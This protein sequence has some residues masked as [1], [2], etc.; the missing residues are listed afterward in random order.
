MA[1][2]EQH[3]TAA[4]RP[5]RPSPNRDRRVRV[6]ASSRPPHRIVR[7]SVRSANTDRRLSIIGFH[8]RTKP[9]IDFTPAWAT[10]SRTAR[11]SSMIHAIG[12]STRTW[13][14]VGTASIV[15][16]AWTW[17]GPLRLTISTRSYQARP[18]MRCGF[19]NRAGNGGPISPAVWIA[20][21]DRHD[22]RMR[23]LAPTGRMGVRHVPDSVNG[24]TQFAVPDSWDPPR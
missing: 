2:T 5:P 24:H 9:T 22:L 8:R 20:A 21:A 23:I 15:C 19:C 12:F 3:G 14:P 4:R 13:R 10:A 7:R 16:S 17:F 1:A 11:F 18:R 6:H